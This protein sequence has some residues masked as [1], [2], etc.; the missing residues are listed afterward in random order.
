MRIDLNADVGESLGPWPMGDDDTLLTL[1]SSANVACGFHAGDPATARRTCRRAAELGVQVGA[2]VGYRDL[3]GFGR[4][5]VD[6]DPEELRDEVIYQI[7]ALTAVARAAGAAVRHVK[8]HGALYNAIVHHEDQA[9]AVVEAVLALDAGLSLVVLPGSAVAQ[10]AGSQGVPVVLEA[11]ADRGYLP[12]GT[13][14]PRTSAGAV[15]HDPDLIARRVVRMV[16]SG[17]VEAVDG[18]VLAVAPESICLH[19]DTPGA[20]DIARRVRAALDAAG[21]VVTSER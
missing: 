20:V 1:V 19:G 2:H 13:L 4:R 21:V 7:G 18:S 9:A 6:M 5:F 14:V 17:E 8:P 11:F 10:I 3:T 12:D 15:L 16:T